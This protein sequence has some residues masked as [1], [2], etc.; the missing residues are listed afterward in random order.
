M[1]V[2]SI[3]QPE[4]IQIGKYLAD[5]FSRD[6]SDF[7]G[8]SPRYADPFAVEFSSAIESAAALPTSKTRRGELKAVTKRIHDNLNDFRGQL[9]RLES[10]IELTKAPL[11]IAKDDFGI[12][13]VRNT[14]NRVQV[15]EFTAAMKELLINVRANLEPLTDVGLT[16]DFA[17]T[18]EAE[19]KILSEDKVFQHNIKSNRKQLTQTISLQY[20]Q[21]QTA[22]QLI[23]QSGKTIYG[24]SNPARIKD[25]TLSDLKRKHKAAAQPLTEPVQA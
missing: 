10:W 1:R 21:L 3:S 4:T 17:E 16:P 7:I 9:S 12:K 2:L 22:M 6:K 11:T 24:K 23:M 25:Y 18:I 19:A 15:A 13:A 20:N 8:F 14:I 5:S